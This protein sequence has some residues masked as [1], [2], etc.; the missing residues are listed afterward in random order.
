MGSFTLLTP[1]GY[2]ISKASIF[3]VTETNQ[4]TSV[5]GTFSISKVPIDFSIFIV[6]SDL[7]TAF[8]H[9]DD[10]T[11][12]KQRQSVFGVD[13]FCNVA[14]D[15]AGNPVSTARL[16]YIDITRP[17]FYTNADGKIPVDLIPPGFS[18]LV[19]SDDDH[20]V[21]I[22]SSYLTKIKE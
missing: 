7:T 11:L 3:L 18:I 21:Y 20:V 17:N 22:D 14:Y 9:K 1:E 4:T 19:K 6:Y 12:A 5:K 8:V 16:Y 2:A 15:E 13:E 10:I